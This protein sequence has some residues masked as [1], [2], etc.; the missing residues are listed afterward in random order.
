MKF[1]SLKKLLKNYYE[2]VLQI[3]IVLEF[4]NVYLK[5]IVLNYFE[6]GF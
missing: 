4:L 3:F 5:V 6:N 1:F 2:T